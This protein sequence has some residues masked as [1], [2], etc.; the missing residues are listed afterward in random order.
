MLL[1][2]GEPRHAVARQDA[3]H[4]RGRDL[5][6]MEPVPVRR[7]P[8]SAE[9]I[10]LAQIENFAD[11]VARCGSRRMLRRPRAIAQAGIPVLD[12][13]PLPLVEGLPRNPESTAD[14]GDVPVVG[15]LP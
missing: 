3:M 14:T 8:A 13:T 1:I 12:V 7:D 6:P 11:D 4:R 9:V 15:R 5:D 10:V 2:C